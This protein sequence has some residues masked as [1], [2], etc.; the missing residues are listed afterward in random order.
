MHGTVDAD[1]ETDTDTY[2]LFL[3]GERRIRGEQGLGLTNVCTLWQGQRL[4][5]RSEF[6]DMGGHTAQRFFRFREGGSI[7]SQR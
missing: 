5:H 6:G 3:S 1:N 7:R 4:C 2:V